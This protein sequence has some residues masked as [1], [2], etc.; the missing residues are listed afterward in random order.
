MGSEMCIRDSTKAVEA[1]VAGRGERFAIDADALVRLADAGVSESIIDVVVAVSYPET[2]AIAGEAG[3][4]M[5]S[6]Q[7]AFDA[8]RTVRSVYGYGMYSRSPFYNYGYGPYSYYGYSPYNRYSYGSLYG[9]GYQG[10]YSG[11]YYGGYYRPSEVIVN[12]S[13]IH[14]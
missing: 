11:S 7:R 1:W 10:Y 5:G 14:I 3:A 4:S 2:F 6:E 8:P 12:L 9:Y 13:L